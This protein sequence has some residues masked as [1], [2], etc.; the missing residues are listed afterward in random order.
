MSRTWNHRVI[1][2]V[3][4]D[5]TEFLGIH[6]VFYLEDG[7]PDVVTQNAV[8][9]GGENRDELIETLDRM[10]RCLERPI[11]EMAYFDERAKQSETR[12]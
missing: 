4:P 1:R 12:S 2:T 7:T 5:G 8:R 3:E 11:I 6:E 9:V 10:R